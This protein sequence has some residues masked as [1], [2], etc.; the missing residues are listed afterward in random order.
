MVF[1]EPLKAKEPSAAGSKVK[2]K[3]RKCDDGFSIVISSIISR[4]DLSPSS[5]GV[6]VEA[7]AG[8]TDGWEIL[9]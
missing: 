9:E 1:L 7:V 5:E 4:G 6:G 3:V 8:A 2:P